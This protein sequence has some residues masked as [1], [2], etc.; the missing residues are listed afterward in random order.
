MSTDMIMPKFSVLLPTHNR[1]DLAKNAVETVRRQTYSNWELIISDNCS[2]D[3]VCSYAKSLNDPRVVYIRSDEFLP[4]TE[5]WNKALNASTGEYVIMLGDDDG[6]TPG[7]FERVLDVM[8]TLGEPDFL[9]HG[10]YIF[11][12]PGALPDAKNGRLTDV[13]FFHS[14][15]HHLDGP[16]LLGREQA[17]MV[18]HKALEMWAYF[19]FNMQYFLFSRRFIEKLLKL[20][21]VFQGPFPDF[22]AANVAMLIADKIGL[23]PEP[24]VIIGISPKSYGFHHFNKREKDGVGL[25]QGKADPAADAPPDLRK[26]LLPGTN[27]LTSW[28]ISVARIPKVL[29]DRPGLAP[30]IARY[31]KLQIIHNLLSQALGEQ[32]EASLADLLPRLSWSERLFAARLWLRLLPCRRMPKAA[33]KH[34]AKFA[35]KLANRHPPLPPAPPSQRPTVEGQYQTI[36]DVYAG[37][38]PV[39]AAPDTPAV[40]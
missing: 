10:A 15:L 11:A 27:M 33:R 16:G 38:E 23:L 28:L 9:Y 25:L 31:R 5:N 7:Y 39:A 6:L 4:V 34:Y 8:R 35:E 19:G 26:E 2:T 17:E 13:T 21:P 20:G 36:L 37:L 1:L 40:P 24:M 32:Y 14:I 12:Y 18:A 30:D 22:Y 29:P 3:D